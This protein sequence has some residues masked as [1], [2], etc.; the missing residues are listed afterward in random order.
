MCL[1]GKCPDIF[2]QY[3]WVKTTPYETIQEGCLDMP[4]YK[5]EYGAQSVKSVKCCNRLEKDLKKSINS[6]HA[7]DGKLEKVTYLNI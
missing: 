1:M 3:Y 2:N 5:I 7:L 4:S 6:N